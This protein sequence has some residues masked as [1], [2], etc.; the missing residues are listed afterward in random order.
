MDVLVYPR[1][2]NRV[3]ELVTPLKPLEAMARGKL[4]VASDVGGHREMVF[5]G[6]NGTLFEAG[7][8]ASQA[9]ACVQLVNREWDWDRLRANGREYVREARSWEHNVKIYDRLYQQMLA[10]RTQAGHDA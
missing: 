2:S 10:G 3:T 1:V 4:V 5:P 8:P 6:R 9:D 7:N